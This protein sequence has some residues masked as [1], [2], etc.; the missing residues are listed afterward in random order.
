M[1]F[2]GSITA[3]IMKTFPAAE[4]S[5]SVLAADRISSE[6]L[7]FFSMA[8]IESSM[9]FSPFPFWN[10]VKHVPTYPNLT[11]SAIRKGDIILI[12]KDWGFLLQKE[13]KR[14]ILQQVFLRRWDFLLLLQSFYAQTYVSVS[15]FRDYHMI[16]IDGKMLRNC[17]W[18]IAS[19]VFEVGISWCFLEKPM[20]GTVKLH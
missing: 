3:L 19:L 15:E 14:N 10:P 18:P 11:R 9:L 8:R 12:L 2:S 20:K 13:P 5:L 4:T 17:E 6:I 16:V 7:Y 1:I